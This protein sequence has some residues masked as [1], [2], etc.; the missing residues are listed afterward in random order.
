VIN[1]PKSLVREI[2]R[3]RVVFFLGAGVSSSSTDTKGNRPQDWKGFLNSAASLVHD[4][5]IKA[6]IDL[7]ISQGRYLIALEAISEN[8]HQS[9]Y[10]DLL[11]QSFN[12]PTFK[13]SELHETIHALDPNIVITTNFDKIY[14]KYCESTTEDGYKVVTYEEGNLGDLIRTDHRIIIKAHGSINNI[15]G[16]IFTKS[17]YHKAKKDYSS[18]Y[19]MLKAIFLT[20]TCVFI[21][22]GMDDPDVTLLLEDVK[23][24]SSST[25]PHY[26]LILKGEHSQFSIMDWEKAYNI[27]ALE[28]KDSHEDLIT[29]LK[30]LLEQTESFRITGNINS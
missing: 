23:I 26:A 1:W 28:Y 25:L 19:E 3:R 5:Q 9:D 24:T 29:N 2:S 17:Q 6:E 7:L 14:E 18:F 15:Q 4:Q 13:E 30:I 16:M 12:N 11:N 27:K 10:Q 21:G 8:C 22:C 20:H